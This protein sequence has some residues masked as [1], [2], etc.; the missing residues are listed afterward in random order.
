MARPTKQG[1]D[2]F[3][4]DVDLLS[5]EKLDF[6]R[7][8]YGAVIN[9]VY[10]SLLCFLYKKHGYYIPYETESEKQDCI[11]FIYKNTRGGKYPIKKEQIAEL[12]EVCVERGLF[13]R[14]HYPKIITSERAQATFYSC[15]V[16]R[17]EID[18]D[19]SK[20]LLTDEQMGKLSKRHSYYLSLH[21]NSF[22]TEKPSKSTEKPSKS[23]EK[24]IKESKVKE[25][26]RS[27]DLSKKNPGVPSQ[28][29]ETPQECDEQ[30]SFPLIAE[31]RAVF[32]ERAKAKHKEFVRPTFDEVRAYAIKR[33]REDLAERFYE[34][35]E[36]GDWIDSKGKP[37]QNWKQKFLTWESEGRK[38]S[39]ASG[40][41][42]GGTEKP[43]D[44][45]WEW[46][47]VGATRKKDE[48][49]KTRVFE[50]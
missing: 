4:F 49:E 19:G 23:T 3:P 39:I 22:S 34:Y 13:S 12:I 48:R 18:I 47:V 9:D 26:D 30:I 2:Y 17:T 6:L 28:A 45:R 43:K 14:D 40:G 32:A 31:E 37:V 1:L 33:G 29:P 42:V 38:T 44:P 16:D 10:I 5:D 24:P 7:E 41:E 27:I 25:K 36:V 15:T 50:I 20:W 46:T 11:W 35:F 21:P 8:Q